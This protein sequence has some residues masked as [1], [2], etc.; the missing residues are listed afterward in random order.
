MAREPMSA[1][2]NDSL[3]PVHLRVSEDR[4]ALLVSFRVGE[5]GLD[6]VLEQVVQAAAELTAPLPDP[7]VLRERLLELA[8]PEGAVLDGVLAEGTPPTAPEHGRLEWAGDFFSAGFMVDERT[9]ALDY[10]RRKARTAVTEGEPLVRIIPPVPGQSGTDVLGDPVPPEEARPARLS[11]GIGVRYDEASAT[12][13]AAQTGRIRCA[14]DVVSVDDVFHIEGSVGL[15]TGHVCHPGAVIVEEDILPG[16]EVR[17]GGDIEVHGMIEGAT[18]ESGGHV[19]VSG[20]IAGADEGCTIAAAGGVHARFIL[21]AV[22]DAGEDVTVEKEIVHSTIRT[23]GAI[24]VEGGRIVGGRLQAL[25]GVVAG[26]IGTEVYV[27]TTIVAGEDYRLHDRIVP[28]E[29]RLRQHEKNMAQI[30][31]TVA[32]LS[33]RRYALPAPKKESLRLLEAE[34][35]KIRAAWKALRDEI[36]EIR[37]ESEERSEHRVVVKKMLWPESVFSIQGCTLKVAEATPGPVVVTY[38]DDDLCILPYTRHEAVNKEGKQ[39]A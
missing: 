19:V 1:A 33:P 25:A 5:E 39:N 35:H 28:L 4:M 13:Y 34:G 16:S 29:H 6:P 15:E 7:A 27:P 14:S 20:G 8:G 23:R 9:G 22:I 21:D 2:E 24:N 32:V 17:A 18:V 37:H 38:A 26:R 3:I 30:D 11:G 36:D 12:Y 10:R 31:A